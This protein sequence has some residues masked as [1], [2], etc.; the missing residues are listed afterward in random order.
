MNTRNYIILVVTLSIL[1]GC[2]PAMRSGVKVATSLDTGTVTVSTT[3]PTEMDAIACP[4]DM[5][6]VPAVLGHA[7]FCMDIAT[8]PIQGHQVAANGCIV[9]GKTLCSGAEYFQAKQL[10]IFAPVNYWASD[11][12]NSGAGTG[13]S[14]RFNKDGVSGGFIT[15]ASYESKCCS[16]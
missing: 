13:Q 5:V 8:Q 14:Y 9:V 1:T 11:T 16:R 2:G 10:D 12:T 7:A 4:A 6:T 15:N 3:I